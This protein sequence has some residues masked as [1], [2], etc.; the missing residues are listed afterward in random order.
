M[1]DLV[2]LVRWAPPSRR[3][4]HQRDYRS[5]ISPRDPPFSSSI[6]KQPTPVA[7]AAKHMC[8]CPLYV[9][10][11]QV[12]LPMRMERDIRRKS[13]SGRQAR[14]LGQMWLMQINGSTNPP[15]T[16]KARAI[17][18]WRSLGWKVWGLRSGKPFI[19]QAS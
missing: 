14:Q 13:C 19:N 12:D 1:F 4:H 8:A 17:R 18:T 5:L 16:P 2:R 10:A 3:S 7:A 6:T 11:R 15:P 9:N